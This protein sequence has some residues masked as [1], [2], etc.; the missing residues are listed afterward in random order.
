MKG[1]NFEKN[2]SHQENAVE[3]T[4]TVFENL[5]LHPVSEVEKNYI[6][7]VYNKIEKKGNVFDNQIL[8]FGQ[9]FDNI[10]HRPKRNSIE[11]KPIAKS[12]AFSKCFNAN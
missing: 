9:Y 2:L 10:L 12:N 8:L 4:L 11:E 5:Q 6:N 3:S 1:F 7:P